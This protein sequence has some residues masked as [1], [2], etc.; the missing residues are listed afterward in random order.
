MVKETKNRS[1]KKYYDN[2]SVGNR[3]KQVVYSV[4]QHD[5]PAMFEQ[6]IKNSNTKQIAVLT[7]SKKNA[8][9]LSK[10][11]QTKEI[12]A[13][14]IH[15]NHRAEQLE[16]ATKAFNSSELNILITTDMILESL[17]LTKIEQIV[18]YDLPNL[19]EHYFT[20]LLHV[21]EVGLAISFVSA[22]EEAMLESVEFIMKLEIPQGEVE[23]FSHTVPD[24]TNA[25]KK[26]KKKK[27]RHK[28]AKQ[29][30]KADVASE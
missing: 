17:D 9:E 27:P 28:K 3:T 12:K 29:K 21:D 13:L 14:A 24:K 19:P 20:R 18:N 22:Q 25:V 7:R 5:K 6:L 10:Y 26:D 2:K 15:G 4:A 8:D 16:E 11:L 23:N 1:K 30:Q